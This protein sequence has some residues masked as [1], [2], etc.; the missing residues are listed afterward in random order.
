MSTIWG[1][2][3]WSD[4]K[5][6]CRCCFWCFIYTFV[7]GGATMCKWMDTEDQDL[8]SQTQSGV[9]LSLKLSKFRF[10]KEQAGRL[11][12]YLPFSSTCLDRFLDLVQAHALLIV[13]IKTFWLIS[14]ANQVLTWPTLPIRSINN[15]NQYL[16]LPPS[17]R[18]E[19]KGLSKLLCLLSRLF[20]PFNFLEDF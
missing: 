7:C 14:L 18:R 11:A 10:P 5:C 4:S 19:V 8:L 15:C 6:F 17:L 9:C 1:G 13:L 20:L 2:Q 12:V 16:F 3:N